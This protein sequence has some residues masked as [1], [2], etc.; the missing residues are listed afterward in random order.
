MTEFTPCDSWL[1]KADSRRVKFSKEEDDILQHQVAI[2]GPR[3]WNIISHALPGRTPRQCRDRFMNYLNE[4]LVN[5]P[6][7]TEED[8]L[9]QKLYYQY[10]PQWSLLRT[11]FQGRSANNIKNRWNTHFSKRVRKYIPKKIRQFKSIIYPCVQEN[12]SYPKKQFP[13]LC[14]PSPTTNDLNEFLEEI[15]NN[16]EMACLP[17]FELMN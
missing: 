11:Y 14:P 3:R 13:S 6:W 8:D 7:T 12:S 2:F 10:G 4:N 15:Q 9:L 5:G 17:K 1:D 16:F